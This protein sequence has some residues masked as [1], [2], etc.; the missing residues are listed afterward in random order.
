MK[1]IHHPCDWFFA[2]LTQ[3]LLEIWDIPLMPKEWFQWFTQSGRLKLD[4]LTADQN[5]RF[6]PE[7]YIWSR[8]LSKHKQIQFDH[9][10]DVT[11][12]NLQSSEQYVARNLQIF[13]NKFLGIDSLSHPQLGK[14]LPFS[15]STHDNKLL[16][17]KYG[18]KNDLYLDWYSIKVYLLR[19]KILCKTIQRKIQE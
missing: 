4:T 13:P 2:G 1:R 19:L 7:E 8:F 6:D 10:F 3:D 18:I 14:V 16:A 12:A 17:R 5:C 9:S 15:Y 11:D